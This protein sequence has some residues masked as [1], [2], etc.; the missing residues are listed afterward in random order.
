MDI[1]LKKLVTRIQDGKGKATAELRKAAFNNS[2]LNEPL[3]SFVNKV[4]IS[5]YKITDSDI[6]TLI[7]NGISEDEVFELAICASV[8]QSLR[9]YENAL[10]A[11]NEIE[12]KINI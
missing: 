5:A 9:Q 2:N 12:N 6:E 7:K 1:L 8:G 10:K 11:L 4:A 3:K